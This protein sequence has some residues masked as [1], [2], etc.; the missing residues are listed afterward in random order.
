AV[1]GRQPRQG[2][3]AAQH[4]ARRPGGPARHRERHLDPADPRV[5]AGVLPPGRRLR[6]GAVAVSHPA[7]EGQ[8]IGKKFR[9]YKERPTSIKARMTKF[10]VRAEEFW[11]L[12]DVAFDVGEGS[13]TGL[14]GPNGSGKSTLLRIIAGILR[15]TEGR[16]VT[17]GRIAA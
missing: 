8:D 14:I 16:V 2:D 1:R 10:R 17:R 4:V 9:R 3:A 6:G 11:A 15:P 7:I 12:K 13:T 5:L